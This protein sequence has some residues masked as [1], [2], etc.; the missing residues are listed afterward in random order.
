MRSL[1][2]RSVAVRNLAVRSLPVHV[3]LLA[4][5]TVPVLRSPEQP[6]APPPSPTAA[7][8]AGVERAVFAEVNRLR[9]AAGIGALSRS[10]A[11]DRA[12]R[13]HSEELAE[14]RLLDHNSTDAARR[15]PGLRVSAVGVAW[16]A[17]AENLAA[18]SGTAGSVAAQTGTLWLNSPDHRSNMLSAR[19][20][21][22]GVGVAVDRRGLWYVTQVYVLPQPGR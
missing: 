1:V 3:L 4:G 2:V 21:H 18:M 13:E 5:C 11:L 8:F 20:T 12:A 7:T 19:F 15:T 16:T 10:A 22:S 6:A 17:V 14:R 9:A